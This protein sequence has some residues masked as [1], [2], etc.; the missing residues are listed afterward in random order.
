MDL[1]E[2]H[3][4]DKV[5]AIALGDVEWYH[6]LRNTLYHDGNGVTVDAEKVDAYFQVAQL[7][8][9][10]L[11]GIPAFTRGEPA[12]TSML[13]EFVVKWGQLERHLRTLGDK[14]L[15]KGTASPRTATSIYDGLIAKGVLPAAQRASLEALRMARN[16]AVHGMDVP[17]QEEMDRLMRELDEHLT[18]VAKRAKE[19]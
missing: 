18:R 8:F 14:H 2:Q 12:P 17:P 5:S 1:L 16:A 9:E 7:L 3:A 10:S 15:P 13:G 4:V 6:R 19:P 11:F